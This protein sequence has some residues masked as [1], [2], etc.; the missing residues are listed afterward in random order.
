MYAPRAAPPIAVAILFCVGL[1][2]AAGAE[3]PQARQRVE[4]IPSEEVGWS[5]P[6]L[7]APLTRLV[8]GGGGHWYAPRAIEVDT[9]PPGALLELHYLRGNF[10]KAYE[11]VEAPARVLLP[12]RIEA[13]AD[14][15]VAIRARLDGY[16]QQEARAEVRSRIVR[17]QIA[18]TPLPNALA[19]FAHRYFGGRGSLVFSTRESADF[20][21]QTRPGG[22]RVLLL[23]TRIESAARAAL[24]A[25][26]S[27]L[28]ESLNARQIGE[29]LVVTVALAAGAHAARLE[30]RSRH[31]RDPLRELHVLSIDLVPEDG[32]LADVARIRDLLSRMQP[33]QVTDCALEFE[34]QLRSELDPEALERTSA[35]DG[36][37]RD[38]FTRAALKRLGELSP[39]GVI[40]LQDGSRWRGWL[41]LELEAAALRAGSAFGYLAL[42]RS[43][44]EGLEPEPLRRPVLRGL[45]APDLPAVRFDEILDAAER[46]ERACDGRSA[47]RATP[48]AHSPAL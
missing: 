38:R 22:M 29:D 42:L 36:S 2:L 4:L 23:G 45:T 16:R 31:W 13:T 39:G 32:G 1:G 48:P 19:A 44:V 25:S 37:Y 28:V 11:R 3:T 8:S 26:R 17:V 27:S 24:D 40:R 5:W 47:R 9:D 34:A 7:F 14:D 15:A 10:Q 21:L 41:P 12:S 30:P 46:R 33:T 43:V 6:R 20:R 35:L 18:L